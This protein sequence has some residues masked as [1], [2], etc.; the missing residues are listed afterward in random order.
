[1]VQ[2]QS[3]LTA[4]VALGRT[5]PANSVGAAMLTCS[6]NLFNVDNLDDGE[7]LATGPLGAETGGEA[8]DIVVTPSLVTIGG[9][10]LP[11]PHPL[12]AEA[13]IAECLSQARE[14]L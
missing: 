6:Y 11:T 12:R 13:R 1:M 5:T 7:D 4:E 2:P 8:A 10:V 9:W 3:L 14:P